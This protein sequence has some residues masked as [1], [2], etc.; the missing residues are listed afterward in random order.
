LRTAGAT[1]EEVTR[2]GFCLA[3]ADWPQDYD[4]LRR[5]LNAAF[6]AASRL[7]IAN[8]AF[9][10][11]A[12]E[13]AD[14]IGVGV[15]CGTGS[16]VGGRGPR[17]VWHLS[18]WAEPAGGTE[19]V[20]RAVRA[21]VRAELGI[22]P[23]TTLAL[24]LPAFLGHADITG[25][26]QAL[27]RRGG[28]SL[29]RRASAAPAVMREAQAGDAVADEIIDDVGRCLGRYA[30]VVADRVGLPIPGYALVVGG[31]LARAAESG[32]FMDVVRSACGTDDVILTSREPA[33]GALALATRSDD[34][35]SWEGSHPPAAR[36]D[37]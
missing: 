24:M 21:A 15:A 11:L 1:R 16:A 35:R 12:A 23:P 3:G 18:F 30:R 34:V 17:G 19:I 6:P 22:G 37:A 29:A 13:R 5:R 31:G 8:D 7:L 36:D 2:A 9:G 33:W 28:Y 4:Y 20:D 26:L 10:V 25:L 27:T 32:Q 14:G